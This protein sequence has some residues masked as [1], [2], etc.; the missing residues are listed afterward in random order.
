MHYGT[1]K[2]TRAQFER[3]LA[4]KFRNAQFVAEIHPLL[5]ASY[6][7]DRDKAAELVLNR[8]VARLPREPWKKSKPQK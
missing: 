1:R 7:Y 3:I 4:A 5:A 6:N 8:L 2:V